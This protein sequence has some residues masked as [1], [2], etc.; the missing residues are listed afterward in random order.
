MNQTADVFN[1]K[2]G[3]ATPEDSEVWSKSV[4]DFNNSVVRMSHNDKVNAENYHKRFD[5]LRETLDDKEVL[6]E[7]VTK[8]LTI[9]SAMAEHQKKELKLLRRQKV[10][11]KEQYDVKS[12]ELKDKSSRLAKV[13]KELEFLQEK[14]AVFNN[15]DKA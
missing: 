6:F 3:Y 10:K 5:T 8:N 11:L 4:V 14:D 13:M 15:A 7:A 2:G 9:I 12:K 1:M